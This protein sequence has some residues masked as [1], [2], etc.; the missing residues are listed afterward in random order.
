MA[1]AEAGDGVILYVEL[2]CPRCIMTTQPLEELPKDP[3]IMRSL[4]EQ[5]DGNLGV[6]A[7]IVRGGR[8]SEGDSIQVIPVEQSA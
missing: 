8:I 6:Y 5:N 7:N 2:P 3:G 4:V 1:E